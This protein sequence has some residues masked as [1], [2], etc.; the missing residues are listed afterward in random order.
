MEIEFHFCDIVEVDWHSQVS[1]L[2]IAVVAICTVVLE[3]VAI[4]ITAMVPD[5]LTSTAVLVV[6]VVNEP[7]GRWR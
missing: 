4:H 1:Q 2:I 6:N 7:S 5:S 3:G